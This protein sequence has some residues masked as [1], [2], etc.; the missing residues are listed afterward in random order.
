MCGNFG[1]MPEC[2]ASVCASMARIRFSSSRFS[3][4]FLLRFTCLEI[5]GQFVAKAV[6]CTNLDSLT[7]N[8][9]N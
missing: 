5:D 1:N 2:A 7:E 3:L 4:L 6:L 8:G 9:K